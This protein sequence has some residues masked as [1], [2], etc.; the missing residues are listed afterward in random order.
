MNRLPM[1]PTYLD[2]RKLSGE[3]VSPILE[4]M[5]AETLVAGRASAFTLTKSNAILIAPTLQEAEA[6]F[7]DSVHALVIVQQPEPAN[8]HPVV[9]F[10]NLGVPCLFASDGYA[11]DLLLQQSRH[12]LLWWSVCRQVPYTYGSREANPN[13]YISSGFAVHPAKIAISLP[14]TNL[15][16]RYTSLPEVPQDIKDLLISIRDAQSQDEVTGHLDALEQHP[17]I[18]AAHATTS[19]VVGHH[20]IRKLSSPFWI[21]FMRQLKKQRPSPKNKRMMS[22]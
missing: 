21:R 20:G 11:T 2:R 16:R 17:W 10:S 4:S 19:R 18:V 6:K 13:D 12:G 7:N 15:K 22:I 5:Q 14:T 8:S 9:N 1:L 3:R